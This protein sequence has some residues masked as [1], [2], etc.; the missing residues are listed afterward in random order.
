MSN[1][2]FLC[3]I[4]SMNCEMIDGLLDEHCWSHFLII[5]SSH[6]S[7]LT[8]Y[9]LCHLVK[10]PKKIPKKI[11]ILVLCNHSNRYQCNCQYL[12]FF[13]YIIYHFSRVRCCCPPFQGPFLSSASCSC[14]IYKH[15]KRYVMNNHHDS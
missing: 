9:S 6:L 8:S 5:S 1:I 13:A 4:L 3:N 12:I 7:H 10:I 2:S 14:A 11:Q 15:W